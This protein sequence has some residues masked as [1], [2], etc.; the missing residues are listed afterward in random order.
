MRLEQARKYAEKHGYFMQAMTQ[1]VYDVVVWS[2]AYEQAIEKKMSEADV[3]KQADSVVRQTQGSF[4]AED[5]SKF[6]TGIFHA[7][8]HDVL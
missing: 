6:E 3:V 2:A 8:V 1:N 7:R 4:N 5:I